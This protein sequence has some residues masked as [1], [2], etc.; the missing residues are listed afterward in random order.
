MNSTSPPPHLC[1]QFLGLP[2]PRWFICH[3]SS[4][5]HEDVNGLRVNGP[6][7]IT[8]PERGRKLD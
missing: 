4:H 6:L 7:S 1:F 5:L 2:P 3:Q 8:L